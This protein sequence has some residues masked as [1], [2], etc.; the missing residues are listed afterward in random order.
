MK[1][2]CNILEIESTSYYFTEFHSELNLLVR[3]INWVSQTALWKKSVKT[4]QRTFQMFKNWSIKSW[5]KI[6]IFINSKKKRCWG[7]MRIR[8]PGEISSSRS[9]WI[10]N[11]HK[12]GADRKRGM[13]LFRVL[14]S[15][16]TGWILFVKKKAST[17]LGD[18]V[19]WIFAFMTVLCEISWRCV[20]G[21]IGT[22]LVGYAEHKKIIVAWIGDYLTI[23]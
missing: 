12:I 16:N 3:K 1:K 11:Q 8:V 18:K 4:L 6:D 13:C 2:N 7:K 5:R 10:I 17:I 14:D 19:N 20:C 15:E 22:S 23:E 21:I 9:L